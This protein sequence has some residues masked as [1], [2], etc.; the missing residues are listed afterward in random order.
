MVRC[1]FE[2]FSDIG[3]CFL[4]QANEDYLTF[5]NQFTLVL[6]PGQQYNVKLDNGTRNTMAII[7]GSKL[8]FEKVKTLKPSW[9]KITV[10]FLILGA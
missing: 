6:E 5:N 4:L 10:K 3:R 2:K 7:Q 8:G 9:E 1:K